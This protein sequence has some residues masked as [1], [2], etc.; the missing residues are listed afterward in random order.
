MMFSKYSCE[1]GVWKT[2]LKKTQIQKDTFPCFFIWEWAKKILIWNHPMYDDSW[3]LKLSNLKPTLMNHHHWNNLFF[4]IE[5]W[6]HIKAI[7]IQQSLSLHI[8]C[9]LMSILN[10]IP[11]LHHK[12]FSSWNIFIIV[13]IFLQLPFFYHLKKM[14]FYAY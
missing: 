8:W 4:Q 9:L 12:T 3:N 2:N 13:Y 11:L 7:D 10:I 1:Y 14:Q 6:C 5:P